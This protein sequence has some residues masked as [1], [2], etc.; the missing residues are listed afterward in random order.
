MVTKLVTYWEQIRASYWFMPTLMA[1]GAIVLSFIMAFIDK[2]WGFEWATSTGWLS[3]NQ[4]AG[5]RAMLSTIA[6]SMITVGGVTFSITIVSL[7]SVTAQFGPRLLKNFMR[8]RGNQITLGTFI[9]TFIYCIMVLRM[10]RNGETAGPNTE[11]TAE[12]MA[13][14]VPH[15]SLF[16]AFLLGMA[17]IAVLIYFIH[18]IPESI[19]IPNVVADVGRELHQKIGKFYPEEIGKPVGDAVG[20]PD[21]ASAIPDHFEEGKVPIKA[22]ARG[23]LQ[24]IDGNGLLKFAKRNELVIELRR[25]P[26]DFLSDDRPLV[27]AWPAERLTE[28]V[29]AEIRSFFAIGFEPTQT[30]DILFLVN[31]LVELAARALSPGVNDPFTA[32]NCMDWFGSAASALA[33][34]E[35]PRRYRFDD[36]NQLR[37]ISSAITFDDFVSAFADKMRPYIRDDRNA[38]LHMMTVFQLLAEEICDRD[39]W[40]VIAKHAK[41]L[42]DECLAEWTSQADRAELERVYRTIHEFAAT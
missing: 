12:L 32:T 34:H 21:E 16:V 15:A 8:D 25:S 6:G 30:Q 22:K 40:E 41:R 35:L 9:G 4:P 42:L 7:A 36:D 2:T 23:Y 3:A 24:Y 5:A 19:Y 27:E 26:G 28:D 1:I 18:H 33:N 17:S 10:V 13:A 20:V 31:Q 37:I 38:A 14:F 11:D 29:V 39:E